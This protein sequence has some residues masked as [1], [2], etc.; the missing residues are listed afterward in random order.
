MSIESLIRRNMV[1]QPA[2]ASCYDAAELMRDRNVGSVVVIDE[3]TRPLGLVT[4]RDL[5]TR[6]VAERRDPNQIS[7]REIMSPNPIFLSHRRG[8]DEAVRTL[9]DQGLRRLPI[10][11][12]QGKVMGVVSLD[13]ILMRLATQ[14]DALGRA[15]QREL[16]PPP[17]G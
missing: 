5:V 15:V 11:D 17:Q 12:D 4:D 1:V 10:V 7:L 8:L 6:V 2:T 14:L 16:G 9:R 3:D 13:D